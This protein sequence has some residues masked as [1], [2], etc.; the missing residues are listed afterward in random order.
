V[1]AASPRPPK[2]GWPSTPRFVV[3]HTP[4]HASWLNQVEL[5]FPSL[6]G[7]CCAPA[8]SAP[9]TTSSPRSCASS[10]NTTAP[11]ARSAGPT[12]APTQVAYQMDGSQNED[13]RASKKAWL[14]LSG[15]CRDIVNPACLAHNAYRSGVPQD[16]AVTAHKAGRSLRRGASRSVRHTRRPQG[17]EDDAAIAAS[18]GL[19]LLVVDIL[20][21]GTTALR[22]GNVTNRQGRRAD[23]AVRDPAF[24]PT[25]GG[26]PDARLPQ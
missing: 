23:R 19:A 7:G 14:K 5:F 18:V 21:R 4:R 13:N 25:G 3:H 15:A 9:A 20:P 24:P 6:P 2:P 26:V 17:P 8:S 16:A 11:P 22:R 1:A 10:P 12:T